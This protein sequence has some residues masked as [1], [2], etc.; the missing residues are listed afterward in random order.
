MVNKRLLLTRWTIRHAVILVVSLISCMFIYILYSLSSSHDELAIMRV[1]P[2]GYVHPFDLLPSS[3]DWRGVD[4]KFLTQYRTAYQRNSFTCLTSGEEVPAN[5]IND[6]YCDCRD[7]TDEPSTS[8]C[9]FLV[10]Q[11]WFYCTA[12]VKRYG[13]RIPAAWVDDGICDC[14]DGS[15]E[16]GGDDAVR[17][18]CRRTTCLD[19]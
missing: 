7:G 5:H 16:R 17:R 2:D 6:E 13:G 3:P 4:P 11:K 14:C 12:V 1:R 15:D 18:K 10:K 8:A 9:S 19:H